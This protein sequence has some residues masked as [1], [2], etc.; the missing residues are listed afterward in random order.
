MGSGTAIL[1]FSA[2]S[3]DPQKLIKIKKNNKVLF[4]LHLRDLASARLRLEQ[5]KQRTHAC[6]LRRVGPRLE[7]F[8]LICSTPIR[9]NLYSTELCRAIAMPQTGAL[10]LAYKRRNRE[11]KFKLRVLM[12]WEELGSRVVFIL[13]RSRKVDGK[14]LRAVQAGRAPVTLR[15][16][17]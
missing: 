5:R 16:A 15:P 6:D 7:R 17:P 13:P 4:T 10:M 2:A 1:T 12:M 11:E 9:R 3:V 14:R 8:A